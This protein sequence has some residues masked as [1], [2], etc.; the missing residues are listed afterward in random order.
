MDKQHKENAEKDILEEAIASIKK[1]QKVE[2]LPEENTDS[3]QVMDETHSEKSQEELLKIINDLKSK[4]SGLEKEI[5]E[6]DDEIDEE[7]DDGA[8]DKEDN[9]DV[10]EASDEN[11]EADDDDK[12]DGD[13]AGKEDSIESPSKNIIEELPPKKKLTI[14]SAFLSMICP[15]MGQVY[16]G[17]Y[18]RAS[19]F[20]GIFWLSIILC[21]IF[22]LFIFVSLISYIWNIYDAVKISDK[23][24]SLNGFSK[25]LISDSGTEYGW[26][27]KTGL[28]ILRLLNAVIKLLNII[29]RATAVILV[30]LY[31]AV[32]YITTAAIAIILLPITLP[33]RTLRWITGKIYKCP[34]CGKDGGLQKIDSV[35]TGRSNSYYKT[36]GTGDRKSTHSYEKQELLITYRCKYCGYEYQ[37]RKKKE[38]QL[39]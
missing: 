9:D 5:H 18:K 7:Y 2:E 24:N 39:D 31:K 14:L 30:A 29:I 10:E 33:I 37:E 22:P 1:A 11:I 4:V 6:D 35:C 23:V 25:S 38:V 36:T 34:H 26:S 16:V 21:F 13:L 32:I 15:G 17:Q 20:F 8:D 28:I 3:N 12:H 27:G 19:V